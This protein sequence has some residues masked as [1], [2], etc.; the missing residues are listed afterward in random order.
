[1]L[2]L[3]GF[4]TEID[5]MHRKL[6]NNFKQADKMNAKFI[7]IVGEGEINSDILTIKNNN[8]KE[9]YKV[10]SEELIDF[11]DEHLKED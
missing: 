3:N 5:S 2:R 8:T 9:E 11:L 1:M 7:I 6:A 10:K 4:V